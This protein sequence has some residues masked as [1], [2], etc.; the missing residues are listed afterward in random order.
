MRVRRTKLEHISGPKTRKLA[1]ER[2]KDVHR[3]GGIASKS[4]I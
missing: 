3:L 2:T 4:L 1:A